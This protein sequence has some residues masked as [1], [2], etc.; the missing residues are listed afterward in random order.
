MGGD[1][2]LPASALPEGIT[3]GDDGVAR[4]W[5][6]AGDPLYRALLRL[7]SPAAC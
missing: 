5:W 7:V 4:C 3:I 2:D 6:G 1:Q